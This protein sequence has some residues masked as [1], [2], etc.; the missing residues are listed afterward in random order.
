MTDL[1]PESP[2]EPF[3]EYDFDPRNLPTDFLIALGLASAASAQTEDVLQHLIGALCGVD[4]VQTI[5]LTAQMSASLKDNVARA[6]AELS[7]P[8]V[9][10]LD[11]LD[12]L[13]DAVVS[14]LERRNALLH[15]A[16]CR[17]PETG[18]VFIARQKARG[19]VTASVTPVTAAEIEDD[20]VAIYDAGMAFMAFMIARGMR[21]R[22]PDRRIRQ[23]I[24]RGRKA[25]EI[26]K[27]SRPLA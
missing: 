9:A 19:A 10:D 3:V 1:P 26:R 15:N 24:D 11:L 12:D 13:L 22:P 21:Q 25:R 14:A 23:P 27:A 5:A 20:A 6:L 7:A 17:H 2:A 4:L 16:F 18:E 8:H